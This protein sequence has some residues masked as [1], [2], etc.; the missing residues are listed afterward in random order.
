M[1]LLGLLRDRWVETPLSQRMVFLI[2]A[3]MA[4][5]LAIVSASMIG[6]LQ[7]HLIGQV[8]NQLLSSAKGLANDVSTD[9]GPDHNTPSDYYIRREIIGE[10]TVVFLTTQTEARAGRPNVNNLLNIGEVA[11]TPTGMTNPITVGSTDPGATWRVVEIPMVNLETNEPAGIVT[12]GLPLVDVT[13]TIINTAMWTSL[14]GISIVMLGGFAGHYL[15][16]RSL[17][18]LRKIEVVAG[19]IARGDL[20]QRVPEAAPGTEVGSLSLSLNAMLTQIEA[21]FLARDRSE[22]KI[23]QFVSDASHE[24]RTPLAAIRGY[25]ELYRL[26]AVPEE[27]VGDIMS[28]IESES[29]RMG[30]LVEDLLLLARLDEKRPLSLTEVDL[31]QLARNTQSDLEALDST[32]AVKVVGLQ[33]RKPPAALIVRADQDNLTQVL[34]NLAG[35]IARYTPP[36]SPA[37]IAVGPDQ[38]FAVIELRDHG[39]GI[40]P[41]EQSRVFER[42]YR[43]DASRARSL[44]G[45]GLGLSIVADIVAAHGGKVELSQTPKGGLTVTVRLPLEPSRTRD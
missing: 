41:E 36:G 5:G 1:K 21:S 18:P 35:N 4:S 32:R 17:N 33:G 6:I 44:G 12:V 42:F 34:I 29:T 30:S 27:R 37:E 8:D 39:P 11:L 43:T 22:A 20:T 14:A 31:V 23:R 25:G 19:R 40:A 3:L 2:V 28:R 9:L 13:D 16:S 24:L 15:V 38:E 7:R 10:P 26:G 45:S